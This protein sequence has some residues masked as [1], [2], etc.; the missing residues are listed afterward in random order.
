MWYPDVLLFHLSRGPPVSEVSTGFLCGQSKRQ[1]EAK[2]HVIALPSSLLEQFNEW[3]QSQTTV[4]MVTSLRVT[5]WP[6]IKSVVK[7]QRKN[8]FNQM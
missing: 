8:D 2:I 6:Q 7:V 5:G 3:W 1:A 4:K